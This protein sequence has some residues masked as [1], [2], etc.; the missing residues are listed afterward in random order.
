MVCIF[1]GDNYHFDLEAGRGYLYANNEDVTLLFPGAPYSGSGEITLNKT[2]NTSS[3]FQGWNLVGNP[4]SETA[5]I[6]D[7]RLF[8]TM[9]PA[10]TEIMPSGTNNSIAPMEGVFVIAEEDGETMT[11]TTTAPN[12]IGKG[13][14][15]NLRK[16]GVSTP[17][18]GSGASSTTAIIDRAIVRFDEGLQLPKFQIWGN[19]TKVYISQENKDY[20]IVNAQGQ[21]GEIPVNFKAEANGT[22]TISVDSEVVK[23]NY[24]HLMDNLTGADVDLLQIPSYSFEA[25][26]SDYASRF[27]LVFATG[28]ADDESFAFISNDNII[29]NG[30]GLL[31][32]I[33]MMGRIIVSRDGVH[34]VYTNGM[35]AGVYAL[36]LIKGNDV[37]TQKIVIN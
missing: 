12:K 16:G 1:L 32:V 4:F 7:G 24:L 11:F 19:S 9:N 31:Q 2:D 28:E 29:V 15:L 14:A 10:G 21:L 18:T 23:F 20:A 5:Y 13:L 36:R 30:E 26:T 8:Y 33:D 34:T 25:K 22:Y 6:V 37:K 35:P 27:K 3:N 17:S